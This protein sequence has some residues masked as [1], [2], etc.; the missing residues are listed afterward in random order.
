MNKIKSNIDFK[1]TKYRVDSTSKFNK[2][3]KL[4]KKQG[5]K[6]N[7]LKFVIKELADGKEL[8]K[9]IVIIN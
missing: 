2:N 9:N 7:K 6:L 4:I 1:N 8:P 3:Y 5:K